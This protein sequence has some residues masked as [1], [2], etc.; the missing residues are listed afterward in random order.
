[1]NAHRNPLG[2]I[3]YNV[4]VLFKYAH[5]FVLPGCGFTYCARLHALTFN[6]DVCLM[7]LHSVLQFDPFCQNVKELRPPNLH[8]SM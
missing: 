2:D 4:N 8:K 1:M 7:H 6:L 5:T 3:S